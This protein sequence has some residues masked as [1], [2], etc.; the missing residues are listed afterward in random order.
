MQCFICVTYLM[1]IATAHPP[2]GREITKV[3][4]KRS[5]FNDVIQSLRM[6]AQ[7]PEDINLSD[8]NNIGQ[9]YDRYGIENE[10]LQLPNDLDFMPRRNDRIEMPPMKY[11]F[12][13]NLKGNDSF[14]NS[15]SAKEE[16][17]VYVN[18]PDEDGEISSTTQKPK[19][20]KR[21]RPAANKN[22]NTL[23]I[24]NDDVTETVPTNS[25]PF[26]NTMGGLSQIGHRESQTVVK[27]T[28]IVNFRGSVMHKESDI[29][30]ERRRNENNTIIPQN[31]FNINQE[32]KVERNDAMDSIGEMKK[33]LNVKQDINI[34]DLR[35]SQ[36]EEDMMMCETSSSKDDKKT[37]RSDR[38]NKFNVLQIRFTI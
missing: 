4:E 19:K 12:P 14:D 21:P 34:R 15:E 2:K 32:I 25:K 26:S 1:I 20:Q 5:I 38:S 36:I 37:N 27:P 31:I 23:A 13:K 28:V 9:N 16:I 24:K 29:R 8:E 30:L 10:S 18:T 33:S 3:V 6:R 17:V 22:K 11:R 7:L 35:K